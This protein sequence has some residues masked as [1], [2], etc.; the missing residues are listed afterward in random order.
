MTSENMCSVG[1]FIEITERTE[2]D[3]WKKLIHN[4]CRS[5]AQGSFFETDDHEAIENLVKSANWTRDDAGV[6]G[7][8]MGFT[9]SITQFP[10][11]ARTGIISVADLPEGAEVVLTDAHH[12]QVVD[13]KPY[14]GATISTSGELPT[15]D[16]MSM[17]VGREDGLVW[18]FFPGKKVPPSQIPALDLQGLVLTKAEAIAARLEIAKVR[19][20]DG[21]F[22]AAVLSHF[23][24]DKL[25]GLEIPPGWTRRARYMTARL[26][27]ATH[28]N[29]DR[30]LPVGVDVYLS[31]MEYA[32]DARCSAVRICRIE[33]PLF[34]GLAKIIEREMGESWT[35]HITIATAPDVKPMA[36]REL[37]NW[38]PLEPTVLKARIMELPK[39]G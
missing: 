32:Q 13:G 30:V 5:S 23:S 36:A 28:K 20:L 24:V 8:A 17:I 37:V 2:P 38:E 14:V 29:G 21:G 35:P 25:R 16:E 34:P 27:R 11:L 1:T 4:R 6:S 7:P 3:H 19:Q 12:G 9:A 10:H 22:T 26:G 33:C 39:G 31:V 18:T 15:T